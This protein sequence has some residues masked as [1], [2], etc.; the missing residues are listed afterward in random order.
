MDPLD[1]QTLEQALAVFTSSGEA[2]RFLQ[3]QMWQVTYLILLAYGALATAP[4][5][6]R[7]NV[8][9]GGR[10]AAYGFCAV[11]AFVIAVPAHIYLGNLHW[12]AGERLEEVRAAGRMLPVVA[13]LMGWREC[14]P[15]PKPGRLI[16]LLGI[17]VWV[18]AGL[19]IWINLSR[20]P[21]VVAWFTSVVARFTRAT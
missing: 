17:A 2:S 7:R 16:L 14:V 8:A 21:R 11:L 12:Q 9:S 19:V 18:G 10:V 1:P 13:D 4:G 5:L 15:P 20:I 6:I 3:G